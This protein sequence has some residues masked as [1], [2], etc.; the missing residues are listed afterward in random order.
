MLRSQCSTNGRCTVLSLPRECCGDLRQ[1][2]CHEL[3][4]ETLSTSPEQTGTGADLQAA[5]VGELAPKKASREI[6]RHEIAEG[7]DA[8]ERPA[9]GLFV[10]GLSAGLDIGF[11]LFLMAVMQTQM[12]G[13][14]PEPVVA[15]FVSNQSDRLGLADHDSDRLRQASPCGPRDR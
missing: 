7:V 1:N 5:D 4:F 9:V 3:M 10:S 15:L 11:S 14:L 12:D 8:L 2:V 6:L 13:V